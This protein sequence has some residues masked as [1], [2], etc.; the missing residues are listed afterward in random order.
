MPISASKAGI[1]EK[2]GAW[3]SYDGQRIGQGRENTKAF[4]KEHPQVAASIEKSVRQNAG[5]IVDKM[6]AA[7]AGRSRRW[8]RAGGEPTAAVAVE[9]ASVRLQQAERAAEIERSTAADRPAVYGQ[10]SNPSLQGRQHSPA[11][12]VGTAACRVL[13]PTRLK[14][15]NGGG[16]LAGPAECADLRAAPRERRAEQTMTGVNEIRTCLPR[17]LPRT[18]TTWCRRRPLVPRNDPTLLFTNAGMVQF[19]DVFPGKEK[20][21]YAR[22]ATS[23]KCVR[24]GGKH[25]DLEN[26]GYTARHHTFFEMLGNFS[27]GDYFKER[28]DQLAWELITKDYGCRPSA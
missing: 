4:L 3:F 13:Q 22:A 24:A 2:S 8:R 9:D 1:V 26:V 18:A 17:L 6:L 16:C 7:G 27:F 11:L 20:R 19:K 21:D 25:N 10:G 23:Q 28:R 12:A 15:G 14:L 5:L